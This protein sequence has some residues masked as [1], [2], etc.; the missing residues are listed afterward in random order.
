MIAVPI[1]IIF[2]S[3]TLGA[4]LIAYDRLL[5][6][7]RDL[8]V[9]RGSF[10]E[11]GRLKAARIME[12]ARDKALQILE[13]AKFDAGESQEK[14]EEEMN[15]ITKMQLDN[16]NNMIQRISK[17]IEGEALKEVEEFRKK[18]EAEAGSVQKTVVA[19]VEEDY[20]QA[21]KQI[22]IYKM[23]RMKQIDSQVLVLMQD[24][25]KD[26]LGKT[27]DFDTHR[28]LIMEALEET[29]KEH[30]FG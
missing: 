3:L 15:R 18:L 24:L 1:L 6:E 22:E 10:E 17:S 28:E 16:Y 7:L 8:R 19:R 29:K 21:K 27:I 12:E 20:A 11:G 4:A 9:E 26:I 5:R 13:G 30:V 2:L 23:E 14:V 25:G